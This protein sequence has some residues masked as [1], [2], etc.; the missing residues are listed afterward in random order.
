MPRMPRTHRYTVMQARAES[1]HT[2]H[3]RQSILIPTSIN[4]SNVLVTVTELPLVEKTY[5]C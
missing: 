5:C 2:T 1:W 3:K 4:Y